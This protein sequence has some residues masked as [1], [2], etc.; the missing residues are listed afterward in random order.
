MLTSGG[1]VAAH[2]VKGLRP[3]FG[4]TAVGHFLFEFDHADIALSL[5]VVKGCVEVRPKSQ[6]FLPVGLQAI[7]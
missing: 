4:T 1:K 6:G 5:V 7:Q 2:L 3:L